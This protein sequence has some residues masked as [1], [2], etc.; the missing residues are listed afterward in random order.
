MIFPNSHFDDWAE[1]T[2]R[3]EIIKYEFGKSNQPLS[4]LAW[5]DTSSNHIL[6]GQVQEY[7]IH[8]A[9]W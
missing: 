1:S 2:W 8:H 4:P 7:K 3:A 5:Q 9:L 6:D